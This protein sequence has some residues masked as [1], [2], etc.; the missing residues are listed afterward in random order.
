VG[1]TVLDVASCIGPPVS[2]PP[3]IAMATLI[4]MGGRRQ[5]DLNMVLFV[6][7]L[8]PRHIWGRQSLPRLCA[9]TGRRRVCV[10]V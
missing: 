2:S 9:D 1:A 3:S 6:C 8:T 10:F 4:C 5:R 7:I